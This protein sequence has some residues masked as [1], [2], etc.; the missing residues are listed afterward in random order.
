M[1]MNQYLYNFSKYTE[2]V[3]YGILQKFLARSARV[4]P[5]P[6]FLNHYLLRSYTPS[7]GYGFQRVITDHATHF[8]VLIYNFGAI[9][10]YEKQIILWV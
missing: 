9:A 6:Y 1:M 7:L 2:I 5:L 4:Q 3:Y 8:P 10:T